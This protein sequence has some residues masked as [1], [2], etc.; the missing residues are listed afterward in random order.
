MVSVS[1]HETS[2]PFFLQVLH[3]CLD[4]YS[5]DPWVFS[6]V[7]EACFLKHFFL[8]LVSLFL[9]AALSEWMSGNGHVANFP[10]K[11]VA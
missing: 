1:P 11:G 6:H 3:L 10:Q 5:C 2:G 9:N 7:S 8:L 4:E